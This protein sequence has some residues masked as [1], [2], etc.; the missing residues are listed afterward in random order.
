MIYE[1]GGMA[2][3]PES[4]C[5]KGIKEGGEDIHRFLLLLKNGDSVR[6]EDQLEIIEMMIEAHSKFLDLGT[7]VL[8]K[9]LNIGEKAS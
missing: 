5:I 7:A 4:D 1:D 8:R 2:Q 6:T 3:V 9:V